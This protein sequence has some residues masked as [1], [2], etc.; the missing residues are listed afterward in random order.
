MND[1]ELCLSGAR[2]ANASRW[3]SDQRRSTGN[4]GNGA[5]GR[6][7]RARAAPVSPLRPDSAITRRPTTAASTASESDV[8]IASATSMYLSYPH[9]LYQFSVRLPFSFKV[10]G[11]HYFYIFSYIHIHP[12]TLIIL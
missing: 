8:A 1:D 3:V 10:Y 5:P 7:V 6:S 4:G 9:Y 11:I 12:I 2:T